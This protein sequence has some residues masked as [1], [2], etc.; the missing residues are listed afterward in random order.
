VIKRPYLPIVREIEIEIE[1]E[2]E[3]E[4]IHLI[5]SIICDGNQIQLRF[6]T[7]ELLELSVSMNVSL[8]EGESASKNGEN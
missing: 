4:I 1:M 8:A 6:T 5:H 7:M 2:M 3:M